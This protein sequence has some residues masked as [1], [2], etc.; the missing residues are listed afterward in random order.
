M[1]LDIKEIMELLP[2]RPPFLLVDRIVE[3]E[4]GR[5]AKGVKCVSMNEPFF[6]GHFPGQPIM[7]GVLILEALAQTGAVAALSLP[8]NRGRLAVFGGVKNCRFKK[9]VTPGDVLELSCELVERRGPIGY[10][11]A[12]AR[13]GGKI[14]AQAELT[15]VIQ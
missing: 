7:P 1:E 8:E 10:G 13:V 15:F 14:A 12:V 11:K 6:P 2:H 9:P 3:C 4:P 5:S